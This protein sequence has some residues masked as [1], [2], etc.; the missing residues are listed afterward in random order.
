[1]YGAWR[2]PSTPSS[3][4][5]EGRVELYICSP[6]GISWPVI[7]WTLPSFYVFKGCGHK[8]NISHITSLLDKPTLTVSYQGNWS[9]R[10]CRLFSNAEA[11]SWWSQIYRLSRSRNGCDRVADNTGQQLMSTAYLKSSS[12]DR[13]TSHLRRRL[14][15]KVAEQKYSLMW[16]Y[17][18]TN[19]HKWRPKFRLSSITIHH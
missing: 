5:V 6:S 18:L 13:Q 7:G 9:P 2:W 19:T 12:H 15:G 16:T 1:M 3:A 17:F 14:C 8:I 4:E 11:K 10:D